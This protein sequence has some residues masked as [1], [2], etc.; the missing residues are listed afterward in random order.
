M[1]VRLKIVW[2]YVLAL[3]FGRNLTLKGLYQAAQQQF[4][5]QPN[6]LSGVVFEHSS[7]ASYERA[8]LCHYAGVLSGTLSTKCLA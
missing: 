1:L 3:A 6:I 4:F 2:Q 7:I 8:K 5:A